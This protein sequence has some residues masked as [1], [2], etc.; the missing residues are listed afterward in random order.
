MTSLI[1]TAVRKLS[2]QSLSEQA[3]RQQLEAEFAGL[4]DLDSRIDAVFKRLNEL[5][6][7]NDLRL[8]K[9]MAQ[10]YAHKGDRFITRLLQ[11][12]GFQEA[13]ISQALSSLDN[14]VSRALEEAL[15][16]SGAAWDNSEQLVELLYRFLSGRA[17]SDTTIH[18]VMNRIGDKKRYQHRRAA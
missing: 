11:Q 13:V 1:D 4:S 18:A 14:E 2:E 3:L 7:L 15:I 17:F 16:K 6:L 5:Q 10:H 8:A 12:K 9:N